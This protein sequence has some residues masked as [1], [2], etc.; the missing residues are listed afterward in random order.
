MLCWGG[1]PQFSAKTQYL[2]F[3]LQVIYIIPDTN[4]I[5]LYDRLEVVVDI[6][7]L[8]KCSEMNVSDVVGTR[9]KYGLLTLPDKKVV[10]FQKG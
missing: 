9:A 4:S 1:V 5:I 2:S 3:I 8:W 7:I 6:N 10:S